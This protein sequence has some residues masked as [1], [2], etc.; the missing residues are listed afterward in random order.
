M[1]PEC[2]MGISDPA[3]WREG[4]DS[5]PAGPSKGSHMS[6]MQDGTHQMGSM[7]GVGTTR[8]RMALPECRWHFTSADEGPRH[9]DDWPPPIPRVGWEGRDGMLKIASRILMIYE[10]GRKTRGG[11]MMQARSPDPIDRCKR[12]RLTRC[13]RKDASGV[14]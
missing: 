2:E 4:G 1:A 11:L 3:P 13:G 10:Q 12:G 9:A 8:V 7:A 14:D 5:G 6:Q